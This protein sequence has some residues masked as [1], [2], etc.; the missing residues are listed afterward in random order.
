MD[1]FTPIKSKIDTN[2]FL[3]D[4]TRK[5][6]MKR[7]LSQP[8]VTHQIFCECRIC[9]EEIKKIKLRE[10]KNSVQ[11]NKI[12]AMKEKDPQ[13]L[14]LDNF[15][16]KH[17]K[18]EPFS[19]A[20]FCRKC[21]QERKEYLK[22]KKIEPKKDPL[23]VIA[24]ITR[25]KNEEI[26]IK[27]NYL[28]PKALPT[29]VLS[30]KG[31]LMIGAAIMAAL[32]FEGTAKAMSSQ[33]IDKRNIIKKA[34][35]GPKQNVVTE[36]QLDQKMGSDAPQVH[37]ELFGKKSLSE[38][39]GAIA[40]TPEK[41]EE[42]SKIGAEISAENVQEA[43]QNK[44]V[45]PGKENRII[46]K[47]G[48]KNQNISNILNGGQLPAGLLAAGAV[49]ATVAATYAGAQIVKGL[50]DDKKAEDEKKKPPAATGSPDPSPPQTPGPLDPAPGDSSMVADA[51]KSANDPD[52]KA[53][54]KVCP[55]CT[56]RAKF[57]FA[58]IL[59]ANSQLA[60]VTQFVTGASN[61]IDAAILALNVA[62]QNFINGLTPDKILNL[63][64]GG[65]TKAGVPQ[66]A[67]GQVSQFAA[68]LGP[69]GPT[70]ASNTM[71]T[72]MQ[73]CLSDG[74]GQLPEDKQK[75]AEALL[76]Q[77]NSQGQ[78]SAE[79]QN[80]QSQMTGEM[81]NRQSQMTSE[82]QNSDAMTKFQNTS[83]QIS[84][85]QS[86]MQNA[87]QNQIYQFQS[88]KDQGLNHPMVRSQIERV[89]G[90]TAGTSLDVMNNLHQQMNA[91][92][93]FSML[94]DIANEY[95]P[96]CKQ[97]ATT[98]KDF[99]TNP[100]T[101]IVA[102]QV[103]A[104]TD[105][106]TG[107]GIVRAKQIYELKAQSEEVPPKTLEVAKREV[108][109]EGAIRM[110]SAEGSSERPPFEEPRVVFKKSGHLPPKMSM[111]QPEFSPV[112]PPPMEKKSISTLEAA[113]MFLYSGNGP[114]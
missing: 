91:G 42:L 90:P 66:G 33:K 28:P 114:N 17:H 22:S 1:K 73:S 35:V 107:A 60:S 30:G 8:P 15:I 69:N 11:K 24:Q 106:A 77:M 20:C 54:E 70:E 31:K 46:D 89:F 10:L 59:G 104:M 39:A 34:I 85:Q 13:I 88:F 67:S 103:I 83:N 81:Q 98:L 27:K 109:P 32:L 52:L 82:I 14:T 76:A 18:K 26:L 19:D 93:G 101:A 45:T 61:A 44:P 64:Q 47:S 108:S 99:V 25:V 29:T 41:K 58:S 37:Q 87:A 78:M 38:K 95:C 36:K 55:D 3:V 113:M 102:Q 68:Y 72:V 71:N 79:M 5:N 94:S 65:L 110:D 84:Q 21:F 112:E 56:N 12:V 53:M 62:F 49:G 96:G 75:Q 111:R 40:D 100:Q 4:F 92:G 105:P 86:N 97:K 9:Q 50:L 7:P 63:A 43:A 2:I 6:E 74:K 23:Q 51:K 57:M 48:E 16:Q 80:R